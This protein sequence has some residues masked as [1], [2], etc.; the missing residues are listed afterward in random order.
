M[1]TLCTPLKCKQM[2]KHNLRAHAGVEWR[3]SNYGCQIVSA[4]ISHVRPFRLLEESF[5]DFS[6]SLHS[7]AQ[8]M[9]HS[10]KLFA[11][12]TPI[13]GNELSNIGR[14]QLDTR[15]VRVRLSNALSIIAVV[16]SVCYLYCTLRR[17]LIWTQIVYYMKHRQLTYDVVTNVFKMSDGYALPQRLL[18]VPVV[19]LHTD[20][21][22]S[23]VSTKF[24][25]TKF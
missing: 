21:D 20:I 15:N 4:L 8:Q 25:L 12:N 22:S 14:F 10:F 24:G 3:T 1:F 9:C 19:I 13:E 18:I 16:C 6:A 5:I 7:F 11:Q 17:L 23:R 2:C